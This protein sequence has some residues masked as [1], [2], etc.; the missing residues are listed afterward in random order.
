MDKSALVHYVTLRQPANPAVAD[1][2]HRLIS[3]NRSQTRLLLSGTLSWRDS[4][5]DKAAIDAARLALEQHV[6]EHG[7]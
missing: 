7:C 6:R 2:M 4:L 3:F 5:L 1:Q